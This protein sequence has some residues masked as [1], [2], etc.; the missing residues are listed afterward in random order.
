M[1]FTALALLVL[2]A[3]SVRGSEFAELADIASLKW[4]KRIVVVNDVANQEAVLALFESSAAEISDRDIVWFL[5]KG[6][7]VLTN[8]TG[9]V[10]KRFVRNTLG[11]YRVG[12]GDV[13]L[14]GKDGGI[15]SRLERIDL[16][17]IFSEIDAMPMRRFEALD[18]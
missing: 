10:S 13:I 1:T 3:G 2:V 8:Y 9:N 12:Q 11:R 6:E 14:I 15:K 4:E 7:G 18:Q 17:Q 5:V 16:A